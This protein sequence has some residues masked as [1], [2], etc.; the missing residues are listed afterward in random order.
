[1]KYISSAP[2]GT[3]H[4]MP[5]YSN[6]YYW[7]A[8]PWKKDPSDSVPQPLRE[9]YAA[10]SSVDVF[11]L[12]PTT[13]TGPKETGWNADVDNDTLNAKTDYTT[14]LYQASVF[15]EYRVF[16][17]RYR[18]AHIRAYFT[19]DTITARRALDTAYED[20]KTAFQYY[21]DHYNN[22][23]P[24]IIASH[25]QGST[26]AQRLLKEY[27]ENGPLKNRLVAAYVIGMYIPGDYFTSLSRCRD[28]LQTGCVI[29]WRTFKQGYEPDYVKNEQRRG[30]VTNPLTWTSDSTPAPYTLNKGAVL[31]RF[32]SI[33]PHLAGATIH[34]D[35][36]WIDRLHTTGGF[37]V[38]MKNF[39]IGDINLFYLNLRQ[40]VRRR[41]GLFWKH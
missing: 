30:W 2:A 33:V 38:R 31:T 27:F 6:L 29:G 39:H 5:D 26:H 8:H 24:I 21:L 40:D 20:L 19:F 22:G 3:G 9:S 34:G 4:G 15:N 35:V 10:D 12:H 25:S 41:V 14:I 11:F 36:L 32:N 37:L 18:Q 7:A 17:P 28:S 1:T 23:R 13:F 16:A